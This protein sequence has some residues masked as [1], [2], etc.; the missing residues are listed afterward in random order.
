METIEI[1]QNKK[2]VIPFLAIAILIIIASTCYIF[3]SSQFV[4]RIYFK[5]LSIVLNV[6]LIIGL[7]HNFKKAIKGE[8]I[9]TFDSNG[10]KINDTIQP[11]MFPWSQIIYWSID[12]DND[13]PTEYL[14]IKSHEKSKKVNISWLDKRPKDIEEIVTNYMKNK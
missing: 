2:L 11:I 3:F 9:L 14:I 4:D 10:I 5:I 7:Y 6:F 1:R 13:G 12:K 8:P